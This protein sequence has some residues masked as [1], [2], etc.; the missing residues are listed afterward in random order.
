MQ[1]YQLCWHKEAGIFCS[2]VR[3]PDPL[4]GRLGDSK[5]SGHR[6]ASPAHP[7]LR[8][9][10]GLIHD[11]AQDLR[12]KAAFAPRARLLLYRPTPA[13][14]IAPSPLRDLVIMHADLPSDG[15]DPN[16]LGPPIARLALSAPT[17]GGCSGRVS[18]AAIALFQ[19]NSTPAF[20]AAWASKHPSIFCSSPDLAD[21]ETQSK[22]RETVNEKKI[23]KRYNEE[24]KRQAVELLIHSGKRQ[25]QVARELGVSDYTLTLWNGWYH[26]PP[27][28]RQLTLSAPPCWV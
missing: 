22:E 24:F 4:H 28:S 6:A 25:A 9:P 12:A 14:E 26:T 21:T 11:L 8:R 2:A 13:S 18:T 20:H 3:S 19:R 10:R 7:A 16:F 15:T 1:C 5:L 27:N 17:L 23:V